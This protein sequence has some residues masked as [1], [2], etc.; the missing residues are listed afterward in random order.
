MSDISP[1]MI[2]EAHKVLA[3]YDYERK[4]VVKGYAN[5][6]LY[7]NVGENKILTRPVD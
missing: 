7:I 3:S 1:E 4:P 2:R 5:R 6:P